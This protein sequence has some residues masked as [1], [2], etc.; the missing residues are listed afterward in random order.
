MTGTR[1]ADTYAEKEQVTLTLEETRSRTFP[2]M[3]CGLQIYEGR[4]I[5]V[6]LSTQ[7]SLK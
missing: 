4:N 3:S 7:K 5:S 6:R 2:S 1:D